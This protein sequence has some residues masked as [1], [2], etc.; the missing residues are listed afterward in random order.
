MG[1]GRS[2]VSSEIRVPKPPAKITTFI[3]NF[4]QVQIPVLP[5]LTGNFDLLQQGYQLQQF[6]QV[7][8]QYSSI[9]EPGVFIS[10]PRFL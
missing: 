5:Q 2:D 9:A 1:L 6:R 10:E 4:F 8:F 7:I 3:Q